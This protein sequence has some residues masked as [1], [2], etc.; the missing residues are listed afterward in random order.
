MPEVKIENPAVTH[1]IVSEAPSEP[2]CEQSSS[3]RPKTFD[4]KTSTPVRSKKR[5]EMSSESED[6]S[7]QPS[8]DTRW[9]KFYLQTSP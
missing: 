1:S 2:R 5:T 3:K 6:D 7:E 8:V 9:E 4:A